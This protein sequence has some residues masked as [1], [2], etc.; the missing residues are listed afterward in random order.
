MDDV[1]KMPFCLN[2]LRAL[3]QLCPTMKMILSNFPIISLKMLPSF[4]KVAHVVGD[5]AW[6]NLKGKYITNQCVAI[7][8]CG[9]IHP[10]HDAPIFTGANIVFITGCDKN[11]VYYWLTSRTFP[12]A[13]IVYL[14]SH[15]C[16]YP[17][18]RRFPRA[19]M[20][21]SDWYEHYKE[22]WVGDL[23]RV[24]A[25]P[26]EDI[27]TALASLEDEKINACDF[28]SKFP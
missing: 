12:N 21:L 14:N 11:F 9:D 25:M 2:A 3:R 6:L 24:T 7:R 15:S 23:D 19:Q 17:V 18:L 16:D 4:R 1:H 8:G 22:C 10:F 26:R 28:K 20:Y 13:Q 5:A 27:E